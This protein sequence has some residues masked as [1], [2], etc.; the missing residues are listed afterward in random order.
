MHITARAQFDDATP[1]EVYDMMMSPGY[2]K[3]VCQASHAEDYSVAIEGSVSKTSRTLQAPSIVAKFTGGTLN[4]V[5]TIEWRAAA[6][7]GSR[8]GSILI[9]I[10][11]QPVRLAGTV[12]IDRVSGGSAMVMAGDLRINVPLIGKK[13]EQS[14]APAMAAGFRTHEHVGGRWLASE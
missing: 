13:M 8:A 5:E 2:Q 10:P 1:G 9:E 3:L 6:A 11:G 14:A 4:V 12:S 7:D